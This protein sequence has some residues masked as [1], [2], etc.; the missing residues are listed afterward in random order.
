MRNKTREQLLIRVINLL[1]GAELG[2]DRERIMD[3]L[4]SARQASRKG[5]S[6]VAGQHSYNDLRALNA[7]SAVPQRI[8]SPP[9]LRPWTCL[10]DF[11]AQEQSAY[12]VFMALPPGWRLMA[13]SIFP[14]ITCIIYGLW[15]LLNT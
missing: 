13:L 1:D 3:L 7:L 12:G 4:H 15:Q 2:G 8:H 6:A 5:E 9:W 14:L 11:V 10:P